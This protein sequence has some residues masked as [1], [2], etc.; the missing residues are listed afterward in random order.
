M[1]S[2]ESDL[3]KIEEFITLGGKEMLEIGCGAGRLT[4]SLVP[5]TATITAI[6]PDP[7]QIAQARTNVAGVDFRVG[8]GE[9]L[10][11]SDRS[12]DIVFFSYSL[13]HQNCAAAL[14]EAMRVIRREGNILIIEPTHDGEFTRLVDIFEKDESKRLRETYTCLSSGSYNIVRQDRYAVEH[15][16]ENET[17]CFRYFMDK[18]GSGSNNGAIEK[19]KNILGHK[20]GSEPMVVADTVN[21]LLLEGIV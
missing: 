9:Q 15:S 8:S 4:S 1:Q 6:D 18:F 7:A 21:I 3:P 13:H 16:F 11:F 20:V 2:F 10:D 5:K 17:E 12:F 14:K 19:M